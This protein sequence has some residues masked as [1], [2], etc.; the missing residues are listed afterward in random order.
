MFF[1]RHWSLILALCLLTAGQFLLLER[2]GAGLSPSHIG[3]PYSEA[4]AFRASGFYAE[5]GLWS[6]VGLPDILS[7]P[8]FLDDG[9]VADL[10]YKVETGDSNSDATDL[11]HGVYTR[12]PPLPMLMLGAMEQRFGFH[13][14]LFRL[15][16]VLIGL[17]SL[18]LW[19]TR[20]R[21]SVGGPAGHLGVLLTGALPMTFQYMSGTHYQGYALSL[22]LIECWLIVGAISSNAY[23]RWKLS[24]MAVICFLQGCLSF[25]YLFIVTAT[26]VL[27]PMIMGNVTDQRTLPRLS[28]EAALI[29]GGCFV[30]ALSLH[31]LQVVSF[32]G[33]FD[34]AFADWFGR[35][36]HRVHDNGGLA[37]RVIVAQ[38][39]QGYLREFFIPNS[40]HFGWQPL[41]LWL[42]LVALRGPRWIV[43]RR[44]ALRPF[45]TFALCMVCSL[46]WVA[47]MPAMSLKHMHFIPRL[48]FLPYLALLIPTLSHLNALVGQSRDRRVVPN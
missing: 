21:D 25:D 26:P 10:R 20:L 22:Y 16:P 34:S 37:S 29:A 44:D 6:N 8:R 14:Q 28:L 45:S 9:W 32:Y 40:R 41:F 24:G 42:S 13:P 15:L 39:I 1:R 46:C 23:T 47:T 36:T 12:Y 4:D 5:H 7:V 19:C 35:A 17:L 33:N 3:D 2:I 31:F 11:P 30:L 43:S 18:S 27:L 38:A 48:F